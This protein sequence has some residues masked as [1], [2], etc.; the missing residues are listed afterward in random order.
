MEAAG[1]PH[2]GA[3]LR[4][5]RLDAG[6]TQ[7]ELAERA[8]LSVEAV[9]TLERGARTRPHRDT[10]TLLARALELSL[11]RETLLISTIGTPHRSRQRE[12]G[13]AL[14]A[15]LLRIV[16]PDSQGPPRDNL[17][18]Q[19]TSFVA[20]LTEIREI[21]ALLREHRIV[22]VVG[23][24][25]VGKTR[26]AVQVGSDL[27]SECPDGV[28]LIDL[29]PI[30][31][32]TFAAN[33][34]LSVLQ[35]PKTTRP[36][37][38]AV[39]TYLKPRRLL[40]I[41]DNCEHVLDRAR[42]IAAAVTQS[43]PYVQILSTSRQPLNVAGEQTYRLPSLGVPP[44]PLESA[45][46]VL[47]Y[48]A[49]ALFVDRA[50]AV[51]ASFSLTEDNAVDVVEV[52]R[53]LD[54]IPLA[55]E[56]A[57]ARVNVLT[58]RQIA[59]RL[60]R[61]F[62]LLTVGDPHA[63]PR[64]Q[65]MTAL[66]D[67][68][69]DLLTPREQTFFESMSV[70]AGGCTLEAAAAVC[71]IDGEDDVAV[72]DLLASLVTK[73]LLLT[74]LANGEQR[75]RLLES[76]RQY[77]RDKLTARGEQER[78]ARRH[79]LVYLEL[80]ERLERAWDTTSDRNWL[81]QAK[82]EV[83]NWRAALEWTLAKQRDVTMGQRL[84]GARK[85]VW[86][87]FTFDEGRRW[88]RTALDLVDE[89]TPLALVAR[90]H[91]AEAEG[92]G[93]LAERNVLATAE[94]T[95]ALYRELDDIVGIAHMQNMVGAVL[96]RLGRSQEAEPLLHE[97]LQ[98][99]RRFGH[100][101][102]LANVLSQIGSARGAVGDFAAARAYM[103]DA[104]ELA[105]AVGA[106]TFAAAVA[107]ELANNEFFAGD[108]E[109][110]LRVANDLLARQREPNSSPVLVYVACAL[111]NIAEYLI[112]LGRY[113]DARV[114]ANEALE[115]AGELGL[116]YL[117]TASIKNLA[118]ASLLRPQVATGSASTK[119]VAAS[120]LLGYVEAYQTTLGFP[121]TRG[122]EYDRAVAVLRNDVSVDDLA[123]LMAAGAAM[124][125]EEAIVQAHALG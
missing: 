70:F 117:V 33:A 114:R 124:T 42:D 123:N 51:D 35:L 122:A 85:M 36:A 68:S 80:A 62:R 116:S 73:S 24:G 38:G 15:S 104:F 111:T 84:A 82:V 49:V 18:A 3:L 98:A 79:A 93:V 107:V 56:L 69:Y 31:D 48:G 45:R 12:R 13:E 97:A 86:S 83:E 105:K 52:C 2:F 21:V 29:A 81:A 60:D 4:Q 91:H 32:Q 71:A 103:T 27:L 74:E 63:L 121:E 125:E 54:G 28:W 34:V 106:D 118:V 87:S 64:H 120:W 8:K 96:A 39:V 16:R 59:Q 26:V 110:A 6:I 109:A 20:R 61:R 17:P 44:A 66:I 72:I 46:D 10:V 19:L 119:H 5:F 88:I 55:I 40:L 94:R 75:Y 37:L 53:R 95:L 76:S 11:E 100:R 67:W 23:A 58:P 41:L 14:E 57:A 65:T 50:V 112:A 89:R 7:Q 102:L 78:V 77:A 113:D 90:L 30:A 47:A 22:T 1:R 99:A 115:S 101:R 108:P 43:C 25:G 9:S 92:A